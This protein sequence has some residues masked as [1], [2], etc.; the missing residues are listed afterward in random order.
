MWLF[1]PTPFALKF[2]LVLINVG[3]GA[4]LVLLATRAGLRPA[5]A[6]ILS[7]PVLMTSGVA[8]AGL[9]DALGMTVEPAAFVLALWAL[10][11]NP[12]AFGIVASVGFHVR[13]FVAYAVAAVVA[14]DVIRGRFTSREGRQAWMVAGVSMVGTSAVLAGMARF[15]SPRGP[16]TWV[17][18][19]GD[20]LTTLGGAFCFAPTWALTNVVDLGRSYLGQLWGASP[21]PLAEVAVQTRV[22]QG[23]TWGWPLLAAV[24]LVTIS[25]IVW[26]WRAMWERRHDPLAQFGTF[27]MLVGLQSVL[28]YAL[29]RCGPLS[30]LTIR[31]A[32]LGVF[33]PTGIALL[34]WT[35]EPR[36]VLR[37][38]IAA[39][40]LALA[41]VNAW[42]H[43]QLWREQLSQPSTPNRAQLGAALEA[44][45]IRYVRSDYWTA[46]YVAFM[47]RER[48]VVGSD[49]LSRVDEYERALARHAHE[50]VRVSTTPCGDTTHV[51]P[52]YYLCQKV[53]P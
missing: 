30:L 45:G 49:T 3:V 53:A 41:V 1:G 15:A 22:T 47:T 2:P 52:G 34:G 5:V 8:N 23:V 16:D 24:L 39:A 46:Y 14:V 33:L 31:Y 37:H 28:V 35:V 7:L 6:L 17:S 40:F 38:A 32:L 36:N 13:E 9:M 42:P 19:T 18:S 43:L 26:R 27:L 4:G 25:R 51:V 12:L 20:N 21:V 50:V 44:R 10:R 11:G 29:S 48:V